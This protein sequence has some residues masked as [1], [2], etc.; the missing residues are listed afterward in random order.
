VGSVAQIG[1]VD[2]NKFVGSIDWTPM[3][4]DSQWIA[5]NI[6]RTIMVSDNNAPVA[7]GFA[8]TGVLF[9]TGDPTLMGVP[10]DDWNLLLGVVGATQDDNGAWLFPCQSRMTINMK[11]SQGRTYTFYLADRTQNNNG[12]CPTFLNDM[13]YADNWQVF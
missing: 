8:H 13:G 2:K 11:G 7:P 3:S 1:G 6:A 4:Q 12:M 5:P 9:D 10:T